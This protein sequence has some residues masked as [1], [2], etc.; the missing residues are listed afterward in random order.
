MT[1]ASAPVPTIPTDLAPSAQPTIDQAVAEGGAYEVLRRRLQTQSSG[2]RALTDALNASRLAEFG[3][4]RLALLGRVRVQTEHNSVGRDIVQVGEWLLFGFNVFLGLKAQTRVADV[5][6]LYRLVEVGGGYDVEPVALA[7]TFLDDPAFV[8]DFEE[9]YAYYKNARLL[10]LAVQDDKLLAAFQMGER[11]TDRRVFRW[12][13]EAGGGAT[14]LDARGERDLTLPAPFDFAWTRA[15]RD[16]EVSGRHP[17]LNILDTLFVETSGGDLTVKVEN[18]TE[19]GQGIYS[20]PVEDATQSLDDATF[21]FAQVGSLILLRVLPYREQVWR[22]LIYNPLTRQVTRRDAVAQACV[23]LPEDH[24]LIFPGGYVLQGGDHRAFDA[25]MA[26]MSLSRVVRSPNGE[27]VL[28]VFTD[29]DSGLS[30]L[31]VYNLIRREVQPPIFAHGW[32]RLPDGRMVLFHAETNEAT[33]IHPMQVWQTPFV[34]DV[35][36]ASRPPG[37]SFLGRLGNAEL[38][39]AI[40]DLYELVKELDYPNVSATRYERLTQDTRRLFDGHHWINDAHTG[41][42]HTLLHEIVGTAEAVLD[43]FEKVQSLRAA[44]EAALAEVQAEHRALLGRLDPS[45]WTQI[46]EYVDALNALTALRGRLLTVRERRYAD[47]AVLD[48]MAAEVQEAHARTG[49]ATG[50]FLAGETALVPL[51]AALDT[52]VAQA[53]AAE[54]TSAL[55]GALSGLSTLA[56]DLDLLSE[57]L[58]T[59]RVEDTAERTRVVEAISGLYAR[60]NQTRVR[61][62]HKR[63]ALGAGERTAQF[64]AQLSLYGQAVASALSLATTPEKAEEGLARLLVSLEELEGQFGEFED[65]LP[66]ILSKREDTQSAFDTHRQALLDERQRRAQSVHDAASRILAGLEGR[67]ARLGTPEDLNAFFAGDPLI[68]K[69][70]DLAGRLRD[71]KDTVKADDLDARLKAARDQAVR[72]LRDRTELFEAGGS[73]IRLGRHRFSVNTQPLDLTLLPRGDGLAVHLTG[74]NYLQPLRSAALDELRAFWPVTLASESPAFSR[75][76]YLAGEVLLAAQAGQEGLSLEQLRA[77]SPEDRARTVAAF[78]APRYREGYEKGIHDHDAARIL[79]ALLPL[80]AAAGPLIHPP[81]ARAL[82][83]AYWAAVPERHADWQARFANAHALHRLLASRT[84]LDDA[85]LT[86]GAEVDA[87]LTGAGLPHTPAQVAQAADYL[88]DE[89]AQSEPA[90]GFSRAAADLNA[91]LDDRLRAADLDGT[92]QA[93]LDRLAADLAGRWALVNHWLGA[94]TAAPG[95]TSHARTVPEAAAL[96]LFGEALPAVVRDVA[97]TAEVQGLLSEHPRIKAG[98]LTLA[99]DDFLARLHAHRHEFV[100]GFQRYRAVRQEVAAQE[101]ARLRLSEFQARPLTS[102]VRNRLIQEVYLPLIGDNL[103]KQM[104]TAG[105]GKR[106]DLMGLLMLISPPGYGK[107]TLMEYVAHRL[108][109]VFVRVNGPSLGHEVRSLDPAQAPDAGSRQELERL[110]LALEMG[111]NVMLYVDDIQHTH[112]EFLQKF[113]SLTD[114]TRRIE[115]VWRGETKTYDLRGR[116]FAVV[117][118]GNPYTESGEVFKIPDMLANRADIYNLGDVLG[119]MEDAFALSY[120][121][122]SLTSNPVLAPLATRDLADLYLLADRAQGKEVSTNNLS[123]AY[124]AAEVQE[125]VGTLRHLITVRDVLARVNAAYIASA[126]QDDRYRTEP[127]FKLQGSYRNMNKL[128]EKVRAVMT[129]AEVAQTVSDHYQGEAQL[130]TTGAEENL[131]KLAE[132]RGTLTPDQAARWDQIR[133]D[134]LRNKA[135]GGEDADTGARLVAQLADIAQGVQGLGTLQAPAV[136]LSDGLSEALRDGLAPLLEELLRELRARPEGVPSAPAPS[137]EVPLPAA[138]ASL[139]ASLAATTQQQDQTN[140]AIYEL[141]DVIRKRQNVVRGV[142]GVLPQAGRHDSSE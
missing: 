14:Y 44:T 45:A 17:H 19:T 21:E 91:A 136:S 128:A 103:A 73:V 34:S 134:F 79:G 77:Q 104:G 38:V 2:L 82:A 69:V 20:E 41:G 29:Q 88:R 64:A 120:L 85:A 37:T 8:R 40:S 94:L 140:A 78:A 112:P 142:P 56:A 123:H 97:L 50:T 15:G 30:A 55:A 80:L 141:V 9:L 54:T 12:A 1:D 126:A 75:A 118:A 101:R 39:R 130:L 35:F 109:L 74:T 42:L 31:L 24:G 72:A 138:L 70:R 28:Y 102:F 117:M 100:P 51:G 43:E 139:L 116:K 49:Q 127:P 63:R 18:N 57:L 60:V 132:L 76:E 135:M 115:G 86:L 90:L 121:E 23:S 27:D 131:L 105:E 137:E 13:L 53:D 125:L 108:G 4:S 107:T 93:S 111:S 3:D 71:L 66:D 113:I 81:H 133:A 98:T 129:D 5:F 26:G 62:E 84:A 119:G 25:G 52:L 114:G 87:Y 58:T 83:A 65:F 47:P 59:L 10:A 16:L 7:G 92:F 67:T 36:A 99:A 68:L 124:S 106:S 33:R 95:W 46:A 96:R 6:G 122:N 32:A 110:N 22:G 89:L 48:R 11:A 61:A